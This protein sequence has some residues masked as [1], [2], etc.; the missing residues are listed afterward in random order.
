MLDFSG[1]DEKAKVVMLHYAKQLK[2]S[3]IENLVTKEEDVSNID[4]AKKLSIFYWQM[5]DSSALD[6][7]EGNIVLGE[8]DLQYWMERLLNIISGY[9]STRGYES[10]WDEVSDSM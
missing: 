4:E 7:V 1:S 6:K 8:S 3:Y 10:V 9:L 2:N 5:L